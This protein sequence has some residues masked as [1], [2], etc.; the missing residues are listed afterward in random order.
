M[1][2]PNYYKKVIG[3]EWPGFEDQAKLLN[4]H[5]DSQLEVFFGL[6][7]CGV[8]TLQGNKELDRKYQWVS[9]ASNALCFLEPFSVS[10]SGHGQSGSYLEPQC[11]HGGVWDYCFHRT[12][13]NGA[14]FDDPKTS[15]D[16]LIDVDGWGVHKDQRERDSK[17]LNQTN[18]PAIR[19]LE[20]RFNNMW[21]A[22]YCVLRCT[23]W[24]IAEDID[25]RILTNEMMVTRHQEKNHFLS[26]ED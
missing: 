19:I 6:S 21:E 13:D 12:T 26:Y 1:N 16:V 9:V 8:Y 10:P 15:K 18:L 14:S 4:T 11:Y 2:N 20:E 25:R 5:C 24:D 3:R 17:K 23:I 22:A 7:L